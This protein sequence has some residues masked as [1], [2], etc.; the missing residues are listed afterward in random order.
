M[1]R[2]L[3]ALLVFGLTLTAFAV[4]KVELDERIKLLTS[5]LE[6]LQAKADRCIPAE[7]LR[8]A[9]GIVLLD[10]AKGGFIFAYEGGGGAAMVRDPRSGNWSPVAFMRSDEASL[11]VQ[12]GGEKSFCVILLMNTNA[13]RLLTEANFAFS[14]EARGTAGNDS[15]GEEGKFTQ[16]EPSMLVY[17]DRHGLYGGAAIKGGAVS[18]DDDANKVYYGRPE[19][20]Q[21]ILFDKKVKPTELS[22]QLAEKLKEFSKA[23]KK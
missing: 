13:T 3:P 16:P 21:D 22:A 19:S 17:G 8:K 14:G 4:D 1:K 23:A 12:I 20:M 9:Q 18:P 11:G 7:T 2:I 15:S 6:T 10:R 5:K